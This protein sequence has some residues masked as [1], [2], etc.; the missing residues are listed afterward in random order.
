MG[1]QS[2]NP[3]F[4]ASSASEDQGGRVQ[5]ELHFEPL[6]FQLMVLIGFFIYS[7]IANLT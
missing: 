7:P 5:K 2:R 6:H 4:P 1:D 3:T